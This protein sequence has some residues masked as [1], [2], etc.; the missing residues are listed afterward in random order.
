M[1]R[2]FYV[3]VGG[4]AGSVARYLTALFAAR[5]LSPTF[6][7]GTLIVNVVGCFLI[8]FI[9]TTAMITSRVSPD[10]RLLLTTGVIGGLTTYSSFNYEMLSLL[11]EGATARAV[12]YLMATL[13]GC[14]L[15]GVLGTWSARSLLGTV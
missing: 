1:L 14:A 9:H 8:G 5:I 13:V 6:P 11:E 2:I 10:T 4:G 15:A 7:F 3:F 12:T